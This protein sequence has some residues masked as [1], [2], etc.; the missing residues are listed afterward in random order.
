MPNHVHLLVRSGERRIGVLIRRLLGGYALGFN[1]RHGR[2]GHLFQNRFKSIVVEEKAY[3]LTL[4]R[5]IHLNPLRAKIVSDLN[6][7]ARYPWSGYSV[8]MRHR[9]LAVM[10]TSFVDDLF[11]TPAALREFMAAGIGAPSEELTGA[12]LRP[13]R[14]EWHILDQSARGRESWTFNERVLASTAVLHEYA[15]CLEPPSFA[16]ARLDATATVQSLCTRVAQ[17]AGVPVA[18]VASPGRRASVVRAR[19]MVCWIAVAHHGI[20]M[21]R[22]AALLGVAP[23][24]V[25]RAQ[26]PG[27]LA[28]EELGSAARK[29]LR[30]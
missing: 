29:L 17:L 19:A 20:P 1:R 26:A 25:L 30:Q 21:R 3:L 12:A 28:V 4:I 18:A 10:D 23:S 22:V 13:G 11:A 2:C 8:L 14:G 27:Q 16:T 24:S 6:S 15:T 9:V 5:Y 7:L